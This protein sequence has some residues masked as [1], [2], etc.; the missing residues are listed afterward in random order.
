MAVLGEYS[1]CFNWEWVLSFFILLVFFYFHEFGKAKLVWHS[2][3]LA[4]EVF[5]TGGWG[6]QAW[7]TTGALPA[8][9]QDRPEHSVPTP[10]LAV[11]TSPQLA[12]VAGM[13]HATRMLP[14]GDGA[15]LPW[16]AGGF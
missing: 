11:C 4:S 10:Q 3:V 7:C 5:P 15:G 16:K 13:Q 9:G 1:C 14:M 6:W 12:G 2:P 8:G